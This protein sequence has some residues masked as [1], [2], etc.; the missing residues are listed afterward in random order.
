MYKYDTADGGLNACAPP[1][2]T[3]VNRDQI[4]PPSNKINFDGTLVL[5]NG[6]VVR[7]AMSRHRIRIGCT[8][9]TAEAAQFIMGQYR[10]RFGDVDKETVIQ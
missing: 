2:P 1:P 10:D 4:I 9:I 8:T 5:N 7:L 6:S 3:P